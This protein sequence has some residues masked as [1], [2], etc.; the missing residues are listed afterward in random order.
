MLADK[1]KNILNPTL[2]DDKYGLFAISK[3]TKSSYT[4]VESLKKSFSLNMSKKEKFPIYL[5]YMR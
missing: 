5:F 3:M 4:L 2:L 1:S